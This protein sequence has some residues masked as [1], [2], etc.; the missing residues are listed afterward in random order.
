MSN[1]IDAAVE[2]AKWLLHV[3]LKRRWL[4]F[5]VAAGVAVVTAI[6]IPFVPERFEAKA[7]VYV[8]TKTVL[9]PLMVGLTYQPDIDQQVQMLAR[10]LISR[11]NA[12]RLASTAL[13]GFDA[14][15]PQER[16]LAVTHLMEQIR[17]VPTGSENLYEI[18]YR[19]ETP[20]S[21][22]RLVAATLDMFV[23]SGAGAKKQD[24]EEA[25]RFIDEQIRSYEAKLVEA[26]NRLKDFKVRNFG[27]SGVSN[28]DYFARIST[29]SDAVSKLRTEL[30]AAENARDSY[31]RELAGE[32]P[33]LPPEL[34]PKF[35]GAVP[36]VDARL[37]AQKK[38]LDELLSRYTDEHPDVVSA[39]RTI[40]Q[41]ESEVRERKEAEARDTSK[42]GKAATSPVYQKL[43]VALVEAE[44]QVASL[45]SQ[46]AAQQKLLDQARA[47]AGRLPQVEADL[48]QLNRDYDIIRKNYDVMVARREAAALG[49]KLDETS[50]L[51]EFRVVDPPRVSPNPVFPGRLQLALIAMAV[52]LA[53]G[54]GATLAA[55]LMHP[56]IADLKSLR[57]LSNRPS[58]GSVTLL[59]TPEGKR[60]QRKETMRFSAAL[61]ALIV[62]QAVW[63]AWIGLH[64]R[65]G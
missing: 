31:R 44:A 46:L 42:V 38:R 33:Q 61:V 56:T 8:D 14:S 59:V 49:M 54:V 15:K 25:S 47:E 2:K 34:A 29:L 18:I 50:Q 3:V 1:E 37:S 32:D 11:P 62:L 51:A 7:R 53:A 27:V 40:A 24:S 13:P 35:E 45:R 28:Q 55:E 58:L 21:A 60:V 9:K 23:N 52:S 5:G 12:E 26:E 43:R 20:A 17:V 64:Q 10:T 19:G 6:G 36:D 4:A 22:Q 30:G 16:E 63:V 57:L 65:L 48:A 41:L 39:R